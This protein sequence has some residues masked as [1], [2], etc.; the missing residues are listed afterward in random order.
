MHTELFQGGK[1]RAS[2]LVQGGGE[3]VNV[4][5]RTADCIELMCDVQQELI[6]TT[7]TTDCASSFSVPKNYQTR[8][9]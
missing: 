8:D 6:G 3:I 1:I 4:W 9:P 5:L 2:D 7:S